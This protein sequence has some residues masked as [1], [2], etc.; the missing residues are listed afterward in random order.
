M[1]FQS[2]IMESF[3]EKDI[4]R[5]FPECDGWKISPVETFSGYDRLVH[6]ERSSGP[7]LENV[8][9]GISFARAVPETFLEK[10]HSST[11]TSRLPRHT[12]RERRAILVPGKCDVSKVGEGVGIYLMENFFFEGSTLLWY[13]HP[14][15]RV[16][17]IR[18]SAALPA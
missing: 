6:V 13:K 17:R 11:S 9:L 8:V 15:Q 3:I 10:V 1:G 5:H 12:L 2:D 14:R 18:K 4:R 7:A 16:E